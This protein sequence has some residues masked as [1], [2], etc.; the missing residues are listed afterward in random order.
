[1]TVR[2]HKDDIPPPNDVVFQS[3]YTQLKRDAEFFLKINN[4]LGTRPVMWE[5]P[6][7]DHDGSRISISLGNGAEILL[8][9]RIDR[10][11]KA[12]G[13][14]YHVWDYKTGSSYEF[15][16]KHYIKGGTQI[17]H[18]LYAEAAEKI[19]QSFD[20]KAKVTLSGYILPTERGTKDGKG[21]IFCKNVARKGEWQ[22][23]LHIVF[24]IVKTG[25]LDAMQRGTLLHEVFKLY[26]GQISD[27]DTSISLDK[28]REAIFSYVYAE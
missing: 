3:E 22:E 10:I 21:G 17:Q 26:A 15:D 4:E 20:K 18:S 24:D 6:F 25:W 8:C 9:G 28:Q 13:S 11:D 1:M 12:E 27:G 7:G 16:E 19:L 5:I 23:A 14:G 2:K